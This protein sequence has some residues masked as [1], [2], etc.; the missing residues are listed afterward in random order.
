VKELIEAGLLF[1]GLERVEEPHLRDRYNRALAA[2]RLAP[3]KLDCFHIDA[4]GYSP[5]VAEERGE[6]SYLDPRGVNR[7]FI[8]LSPEQRHLPVI[9]TSFSADLTVL[10]KFF[11]A[12]RRA[13]E[14]LTLSDAVFGEIENLVLEV[15]K[16]A[17]IIGITSVTFDVHTVNGSLEHAEKLR[18]LVER[19]DAEPDSWRNAELMEAIVEGAKLC[20]DIRRNGI[21]PAVLTFAWPDVS[22]TRHLGGCYVVR[23]AGE[24]WLF[25]DSAKLVPAPEGASVHRLDD[26]DVVLGALE[27][28]GFLEPVNPHWLV[29]SG[30]VDHRIAM[31][32]AE[33]VAAAGTADPREALD[34]RQLPRLIHQNLD[35]LKRD[36]RFRALTEMR[37]ALAAGRTIS[38]AASD[39]LMIRRA[40]PSHLDVW[41]VN[42][43]LSEFVR[44]DLVTLFIVNKP[45]FYE[46]YAGL[47]EPMKQFAIAAVTTIYHPGGQHVLSHKQAVR[48]RFFGAH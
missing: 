46:I 21:L 33:L 17:D 10:R 16:P 30:I 26:A 23:A 43:L 11:D 6:H 36:G 48:E 22:W 37:P 15:E 3:T 32:V 42:R 41:E 39:A 5:E 7:L 2:L 13:I 35:M 40:L 34:E 47:S 38:I 28:N 45:R 19:F 44:F 14:T 27:S 31:L 1:G 29:A 12:N 9:R 20:G 18:V 25:G 8:I 4:T 24:C